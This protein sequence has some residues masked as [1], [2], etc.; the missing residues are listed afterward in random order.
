VHRGELAGHEPMLRV[1]STKRGEGN[2]AA[3]K[4]ELTVDE[5]VGQWE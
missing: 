1:S 5:A 3:G 2:D 4:I